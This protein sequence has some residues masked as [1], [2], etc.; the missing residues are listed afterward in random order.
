MNLAAK[1]PVFTTGKKISA[2]RAD[3]PWT[4]SVTLTRRVTRQECD[5][6][7]TH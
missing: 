5:L 3:A 6:L 2:R 7:H 4:K 1:V